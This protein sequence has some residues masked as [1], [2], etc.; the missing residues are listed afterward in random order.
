M[1]KEAVCGCLSMKIQKNGPVSKQFFYT[2]KENVLKI[3]R[4][5]VM[6]ATDIGS[7]TDSHCEADDGLI[8]DNDVERK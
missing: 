4:H 2:S 1:N 6:S 5:A 7:D 3:N 8:V